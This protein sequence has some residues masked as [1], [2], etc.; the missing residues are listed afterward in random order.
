MPSPLIDFTATNTAAFDTKVAVFHSH[1]RSIPKSLPLRQPGGPLGILGFASLHY[2]RFAFSEK[3]VFMI[4]LATEHILLQF[5]CLKCLK[6]QSY[7][8]RF[9]RL[10]II[11]AKHRKFL[12]ETEGGDF[13]Q[14]GPGYL[15]RTGIQALR[16]RPW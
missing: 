12:P 13:C 5:S 11:T 2:Y 10:V 3:S 7:S 14:S 8:D 9:S 1:S 15:L 6:K 16:I 4:F